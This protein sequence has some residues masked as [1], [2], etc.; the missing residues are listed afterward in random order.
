[1]EINLIKLNNHEQIIFI[2][3]PSGIIILMGETTYFNHATA[4]FQIYSD[5]VGSHN[6]GYLRIQI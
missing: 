4:T 3:I 6:A 1:M 5:R 2:A